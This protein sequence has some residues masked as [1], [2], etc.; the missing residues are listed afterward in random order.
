MTAHAKRPTLG[1]YAPAAVGVG[2]LV[3]FFVIMEVLVQSGLVSRFIVPPPSE[4]LGSFGRVIV[5]E[6]VFSRFV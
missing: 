2:S 3:A 4:I 5:E 1:D 6:R